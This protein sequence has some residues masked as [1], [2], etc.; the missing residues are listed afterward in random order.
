MGALTLLQQQRINSL[1]KE[2]INII[3]S[4]AL[5]N[6]VITILY[7]N[8]VSFAVA[9]SL[10]K[11]ILPKIQLLYEPIKTGEYISISTPSNYMLLQNWTEEDLLNYIIY[12]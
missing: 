11:L 1:I 12:F 2:D 8:S 4:F 5:K 7:D 3:S 10:S 9:C 6:N